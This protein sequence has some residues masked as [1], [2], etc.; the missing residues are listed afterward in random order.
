MYV[1]ITLVFPLLTGTYTDTVGSINCTTCPS[2]YVC[3]GNTS[4]PDPCPASSYCPN[5]TYDPIL[6]PNGTYTI[7][8]GL[9]AAEDCSQC[10]AGE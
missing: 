2:G 4:T 8:L 7:T 9:E 5:G 6:C 1:I 3:A 10:I